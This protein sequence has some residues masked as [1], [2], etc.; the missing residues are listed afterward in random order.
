MKDRAN[1]QCPLCNLNI[2]QW[3]IIKLC[4]IVCWQNIS[5][6]FDN[7]PNPKYNFGAM[8]FELAKIAKIIHVRSVLFKGSSSNLVY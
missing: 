5:G 4:D 8:A 3:V 1:K 2:F 6:K 7:Q